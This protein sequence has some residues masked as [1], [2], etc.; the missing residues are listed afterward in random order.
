MAML[1]LSSE[2]F[3]HHMT[4]PGHPERHQRAEA[5]DAIARRWVSGGGALESPSPA[6]RE[7]LGRVHDAGY[8]DRLE[9][10]R[11]RA[12]MLD[13]DTFTSPESVEVAGL[14]AGGAIAA[15]DHALD[16]GG[17]AIALVRP[18]GHHA[19]R[20]R[21]M[22]FC[23]YNNV[24]VAAAHALAR[25]AR[26]VA[27]VDIDVHHGN[28][29]QSIFYD[30]PRVLYVSVHQYPFYPGTGAADDVGAGAGAGFTVNVPLAAGAGDADYRLAQETVVTPVVDAFCPDL[31]LVSAGFDAHGR[32]PLGGMRVTT[33]G[34][35]A[36]VGRL[37]AVADAR[38]GGR[39]AV[40]TEGGYDLPA[41]AACTQAAI[42]VLAGRAVAPPGPGGT[43]DRA[44]EA[45][46]AVREAQRPFWPGL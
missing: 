18:P 2:R 30:D 19:D 6:T 1:V 45:L 22:G 43:P 31:V 34:Y 44:R 21:A 13:D 28:G 23:L 20:S 12:A 33:E 42:D 24:A 37:K 5:L 17:P 46:S 4:P 32:D 41:L 29:T 16:G 35:A 26:R 27:V 3:A 14:A 36:L 8:L 38:S 39:L 7:A 25:G 10:L 40:V 11:G 15:V 9:T